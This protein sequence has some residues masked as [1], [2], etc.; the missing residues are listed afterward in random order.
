MKNQEIAKIFD[1]IAD[2]LEIR[3][4]NPFR[5]RAY[6]RASQNIERYPRD[7]GRIDEEELHTIPGIGKD[8]ADK[9]REFT[10]THRL[11]FYDELKQQVP[12]GL[13]QMLKIPGLGPKK[14][15][16][17]YEKFRIRNIDTL[18]TMAKKGKLRNLPGIQARTEENL[19]RGIA[20]VRRHSERRPIGD[21][22]PVAEDIIRS[23]RETAS[24]KNLELAG[25]LRRWK[26]TIKDIDI[27]AT[28]GKPKELMRAFTRLPDI[29]EIIMS[30]PTKS[31]VLIRDGI[32]VDLR[33]IDDNAYGSA[34][35]YFTGSR[36]HNIRLREM[37]QKKGLK[38]NEY[39]VF[40][41]KTGRKISGRTE[42]DVYRS[43]GLPYIAPELREDN[44]EIEASAA[45]TLP[46]LITLSDISG[47]LHVH[48]D[49]SDGSHG[50]PELVD[51]ARAKKYRYI[52]L[53]DHSK[54]LGIAG[55]MSIEEILGQHK[56]IQEINKRLSGFRLLS[57]VEVDIRSDGT[58]DYPDD[59]LR[60]LDLVVA[61][62]HSGFHQPQ[63][64]IT[65]RL[66]AAMNNP[67]VSV[68]AHPTGRLIGERD[69]YDVDMEEFL[70]TASETGTAVEINAY[71]L[72][73]DLSESFARKAGEMGIPLVISTDTH[74]LYQFG[75]MKYGI[76]I[77]RRGWLEARDV[78][79]TYP[80]KSLMKHLA[81]KSPSAERR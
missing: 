46:E 18:E 13:I 16:L 45:G 36:E 78:L 9:V 17:F 51:A 56:R 72:R 41:A 12:P 55:G 42:S 40:R 64:K 8:L 59:V 32:Q 68:I 62:I 76:G 11:A 66:T 47:D 75:F 81:K 54:G 39:G 71:P 65:M 23:L 60:K 4:D 24:V 52:A 70:R 35:A 26:E 44:G 49:D 7:V 63:K 74:V 53:T 73:L 19:L 30:G 57:G 1:D 25:S 58:L 22:L 67:H 34:L 79:N 37:A 38:I 33:V 3:G 69:G 27:L 15:K 28:S 77:A 50:I 2:I 20:L 29:Q 14:V 5:I 48:S 43:L 31:S 6:R 21:V 80:Y 10:D 61:S